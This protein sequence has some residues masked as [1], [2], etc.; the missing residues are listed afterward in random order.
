MRI[1][2]AKLYRMT[3]PHKTL[4]PFF[5]AKEKIPKVIIKKLLLPILSIIPSNLNEV[6]LSQ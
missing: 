5:F 3:L 1:E 4:R 6:F 2:Y